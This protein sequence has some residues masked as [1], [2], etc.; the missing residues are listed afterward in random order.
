M[1]TVMVVH[2]KDGEEKSHHCVEK[3]NLKNHKKFYEEYG[4]EC[5]IYEMN[6]YK[7]KFGEDGLDISKL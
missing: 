1:K 6:E 5:E 4:Y 7:Q 3:Q 2:F